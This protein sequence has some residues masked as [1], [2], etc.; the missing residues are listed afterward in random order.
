MNKYNRRKDA[1]YI[2]FRLFILTQNHLNLVY[3]LIN[4]LDLCFQFSTF[5]IKTL[6]LI[7]T[8]KT[9]LIN[10][11]DSLILKLD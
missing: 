1:Q 4:A 10:I 8:F 9:F 3:S 11:I 6:F 7:V 5:A 2:K